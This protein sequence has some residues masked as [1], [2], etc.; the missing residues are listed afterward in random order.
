ME[1]HHIRLSLIAC[2]I[3]IGIFLPNKIFACTNPPVNALGFPPYSLVT[4]YI[5]P[6]ITGTKR[7]KTAEGFNNWTAANANNCSNVAFNVVASDP[8]Q[9]EGFT[10]DTQIVVQNAPPIDEYS[11]FTGDRAGILVYKDDATGWARNAY[12]RLDPTLSDSNATL[13]A[14]AHE[15]GH[16][17]GIA[18][19]S[20]GT[21]SESIMCPGNY[22]S[23]FNLVTGR[24]T[25]PNFCDQTVLRI[26]YCDFNPPPVGTDQNGNTCQNPQQNFSQGACASGFSSDSTGNYCC[27][28]P[29]GGGGTCYPLSTPPCRDAV[30]D[31][32]FCSWDTTTCAD[33]NDGCNPN[34]LTCWGSPVLIDI[35]GNGFKLTNV[36]NGVDFDLNSDG[37]KERTSWVAA[38]SDDAWLALDRNGNGVID[39]GQELFGNFTLQPESNQR[40]GFLALAEFDKPSNGGNDDG[41]INEQDSVFSNL[42]LWQDA[43]HNGLSEADELKTLPELAV[44]SIDLKYKE[45][46]RVDDF[47][48]SFRYRAKVDDARKAKVGRWAWDVFLRTSP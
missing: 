33:F 47:G 2:I 30:W 4:V 9:Y 35:L 23:N 27:Q 37:T 31:T 45:S 46:K 29:T 44:V 41:E 38:V 17:M 25:S 34:A 48:N 15:I 22:G 19:P 26:V 13:E 43:N 32:F 12:I 16:S 28:N 3:G 39:N 7:S 5:D 10:S 42:R 6:A 14:A 24:P 18:H 36:A 40:N 1:I 11:N 8:P 20:C 21:Q